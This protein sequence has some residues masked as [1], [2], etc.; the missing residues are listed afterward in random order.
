MRHQA[1]ITL[2]GNVP[3]RQDVQAPIHE[4]IANRWSPRSFSDQ[5]IESDKLLTLFE[6]ARW[7]PSSTNEQPWRF[8]IATKDNSSVFSALAESLMQGNRR[9]AERAPMLALALAQTTYVGTGRPYRHSWYDVGQ[10][11]ALLSMQATALGLAV[12]QMGGFDVE[13]I[14]LLLSIPEGFDPIVTIAIGYSG[15]PADLPEDLRKRELAP[16]SRKP[17]QTFVYA[18]EWGKASSHVQSQNSLL[19]HPPAN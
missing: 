9:W 13:Q 11:V 10:A 14:R 1:G 8:I 6:A 16:R 19:P 5:P 2:A 12:H 3:D 7:A 4:L 18:G 15:E 17:L